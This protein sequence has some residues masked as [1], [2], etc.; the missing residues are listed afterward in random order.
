MGSRGGIRLYK[1]SMVTNEVMSAV[2]EYLT[3][4]VFTEGPNKD[5]KKT[6][7]RTDKHDR[8][9]SPIYEDVLQTFEE[10]YNIKSGE[11]F[12]LEKLK[13]RLGEPWLGV[14]LKKN[15][16]FLN[17]DMLCVTYGDNVPGFVEGVLDSL[18]N[19]L[20]WPELSTDTWT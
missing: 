17:E 7:I 3:Q 12:T 5:S 13:V 14:W 1:L 6:L 20:S 15:Y 16:P 10:Y 9:G 19:G 8:W 18:E 11:E 4:Y 2:A